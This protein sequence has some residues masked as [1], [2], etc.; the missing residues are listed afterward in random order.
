MKMKKKKKKKNNNNNNNNNNAIS[1]WKRPYLCSPPSYSQREGL[2][3]A[4][5]PE[6]G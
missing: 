2:V 5:D 4:P 3:M 1:K 6:N